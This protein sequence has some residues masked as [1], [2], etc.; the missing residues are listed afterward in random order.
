MT[1]KR[2]ER[3]FREHP[4]FERADREESG[5]GDES[6]GGTDATDRVEF[7][8]GFT[9]FEGGVSVENDPGRDGD[10]DRREYRVVV[11]VPT[12]DAV[13]EGETVAPVV[14]DG[15]FDT[16]DR[17]LADAHTVADAEVAAAPTVERE[18]ESVVVTVAFERDDPERAA[19]DA[20][21]V[22]EYV[23]GTWVQGL[24]PGYDYR[25]P[26]ASFRERAT[27]NYDEG[28]SRGSR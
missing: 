11:R 9:P 13:V 2:I 28:G 22:V 5:E 10:T 15:W 23:E 7:G 8:V 19:E 3:T 18:G 16:L 21:A 12:L 27:Q 25:E 17:R 14:Q 6:S 26:A 1:D 4:S 24:V 20:K